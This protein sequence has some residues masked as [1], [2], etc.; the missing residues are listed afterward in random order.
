MVKGF[1]QGL[2]LRQEEKAKPPPA[3]GEKIFAR[4]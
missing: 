1:T 3:K 2:G 4:V